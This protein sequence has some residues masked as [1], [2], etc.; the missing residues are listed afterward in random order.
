MH[1]V[2]VMEMQKDVIPKG[3]PVEIGEM[4]RAIVPNI[5]KLLD[6]A[7]ER[8]VPLIYANLCS[9]PG[10]PLFKKWP[11]AHCVPGTPGIEVIDELKPKDG[12]YVVHIYA[13]NA[14]LHT[15]LEHILRALGVATLIMTGISTD[16]SCLLT[17]ME[18]FQRWFDVIMVSDCCAS[19]NEE[20]HQRGLNYL[21]PFTKILNCEEV[22]KLLKGDV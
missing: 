5:Q 9:I 14:F 20:R 3:S 11:V 21:K 10:D 4:G 18:A 15:D 6:A 12:D 1:A 22:I 16:A 13:M 7:R 19:W 8:K 17:A 2:L